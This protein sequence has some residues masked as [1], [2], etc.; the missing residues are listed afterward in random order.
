[1]KGY[2]L[3]IEKQTLTNRLYHK[4]VHTTSEMQLVFMNLAPGEDIPWEKHNGSQFIRIESGK[5]VVRFDDGYKRLSD[6]IA[7]IIPS[8]TNHY[9]KNTSDTEDLKL[10]SVY[11]PPEH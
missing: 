7:I 8:N 1:M 5:G 2:V 9:I 10:Y 4:I 11:S 3:N 6:G